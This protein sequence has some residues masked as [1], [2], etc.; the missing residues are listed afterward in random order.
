MERAQKSWKDLKHTASKRTDVHNLIR[1]ILERDL[2]PPQNPHK[3]FLNMGLGKDNIIIMRDLILTKMN[4]RA[5]QGE[6]V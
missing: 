4:R 5:K 6:W 1:G 2:K 3:P